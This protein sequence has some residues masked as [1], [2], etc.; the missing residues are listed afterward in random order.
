M[1][2]S[3]FIAPTVDPVEPPISISVIIIKIVNDG[4]DG[5]KIILDVVDFAKEALDDRG[6]M[7]RWSGD[8]FVLF[9]EMKIDAAESRLKQFCEKSK[10]LLDVTISAGIVEVDLSVSIKT[11]YYRAVQACYA[12]KENGGNGVGRR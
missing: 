7:F 5:D 4:R 1:T 9:I 11:N 12:I 8:E 2:R 3:N 10:R 6:I